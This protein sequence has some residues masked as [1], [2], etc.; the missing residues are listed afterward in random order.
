M[1]KCPLHASYEKFLVRVTLV[2]YPRQLPLKGCKHPFPMT[3]DRETVRAALTEHSSRSQQSLPV[4]CTTKEEASGVVREMLAQHPILC[5]LCHPRNSLWPCPVIT[6]VRLPPRTN[7]ALR[8]HSLKR[9]EGVTR[10]NLQTPG[11]AKEHERQETPTINT[12]DRQSAQLADQAPGT[13]ERAAQLPSRITPTSTAA[14]HASST[15]ASRDNYA[16]PAG[17]SPG[18]LSRRGPMRST[19][20]LSRTTTQTPPAPAGTRGAPRLGGP[21]SGG[22][23][24][25]PRTLGQPLGS[26]REGGGG[27]KEE[28]SGRRQGS[29]A[30]ERTDGGAMEQ[31][32]G[33]G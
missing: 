31:G 23:G 26:G 10:I 2:Q 1:W 20:G 7:Q 12:N 16:H 3:G 32:L 27:R 14:V 9:G 22:T 19:G 18:P 29:G 15:A 4:Y 11:T 28:G 17:S 13:I 30:D 5:R 21:L 25:Q 33:G 24:G 6:P 8:L